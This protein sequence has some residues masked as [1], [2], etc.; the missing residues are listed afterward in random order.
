MIV[1]LQQQSLDPDAVLQAVMEEVI[2]EN[3][4]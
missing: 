3:V 1:L 4:E 2:C